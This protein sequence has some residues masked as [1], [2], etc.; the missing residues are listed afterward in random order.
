MAD[1]NIE[2]VNN[3][4]HKIMRLVDRYQRVKS[5]NDM[6]KAQ[7]DQLTTQLEGSA[8]EM[9]DLKE[10]YN[11]LKF[12]KTIEKSSGD[13]HYAKIRIN[14]IVREIDKCIALLN[15]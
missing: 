5:E 3:L 14:Q 10:K 9:A 8:R 11:T 6:L 13:V 12:S 7:N 2:I 15:R 4:Q 1:E